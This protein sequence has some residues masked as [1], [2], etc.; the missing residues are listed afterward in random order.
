MAFFHLG[1]P[2]NAEGFRGCRSPPPAAADYFHSLLTR[3][4]LVNAPSNGVISGF[5]SGRLRWG[6]FRF[7]LRPPHLNDLHRCLFPKPEQDG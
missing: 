7:V 2:A 3:V 6:H 1:L 5:A 4:S